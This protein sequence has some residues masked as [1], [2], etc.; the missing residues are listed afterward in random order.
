MDRW[1]D[2][3]YAVFSQT[4]R[5]FHESCGT[6]TS[7]AADPDCV[8]KGFVRLDDT[9][10]EVRD[11]QLVAGMLVDENL[12]QPNRIAATGGSYGGDMSMTLAALKNRIML[13]NGTYQPWTSPD[14]T[15]MSIAVATPNIPWT[16]LAYSLVPNGRTLDYTTEAPRLG[17]DGNAP[18][19]VMKAAIINA[20]FGAGNNFSGD[21]GPVNPL[22]DV[23]GWRELMSQGEPYDTPGG[24][25]MVSEMTTHRSSY[26]IDDSVAPAPLIIAEGPTDDLFPIDEALRFYNRTKETYPDS[27]IGLLFADIGHPRAPLSGDN[28]QGR[29]ADQEM[30]YE[31]VQDWFEHYLL[32]QGPKPFDGVMAKS[33]LCPYT[34]PAGGPYTAA[35]W[36]EF[37][38]GEIRLADPTRRVI[39]KDGG[40]LQIATGFTTIFD[41]CTQQPETEEP[42]IAEY[43]SRSPRPVVSPSGEPRP[44]S[45]TSR[46]RTA[47][48]HRSLPACSRSVAAR[49]GSSPAASTGPTEVQEHRLQGHQEDQRQSHGPRLGHTQDHQAG[50]QAKRQSPLAKSFRGVRCGHTP[51]HR[52]LSVGPSRALTLRSG[53]FFGTASW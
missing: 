5:G 13:E 14:G 17:P 39:S 25:T 36:A 48:S 50:N 9:R 52:K 12:I 16:D 19:G 53:A 49:S 30:G 26:Y 42:G 28:S 7:K 6:A 46:L 40:N 43:D 2:R 21:N 29:P 23:V 47:A 24:E 4:N 38:P 11:A 37:A 34:D 22:F 44:L 31:I 41:G 45:P 3:G 15:P 1:L 18:Y 33:Q 35:N 10:F 8:T 27:T 20:L 32:D 51:D